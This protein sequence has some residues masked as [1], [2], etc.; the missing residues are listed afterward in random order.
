[1]ASSTVALQVVNVET[2]DEVFSLDGDRALVPASV[3]KAVTAAAALRTLGPTYRFKTEFL[4]DGEVNGDGVL[5]GNLYIR[6]GG[7]PSLVIE[8]LWKMF[9]DL[10]VEGIVEIDGDLIFDDTWFDREHLIAGWNKKVDIAAG[11]A[12]FAPISALSL[13]YNTVSIIVA[14][15][16]KPGDPARVQLETPA[17]IVALESEVETLR[18]GKRTWI[19]VEREVDPETHVVTF[20]IEGAIAAEGKIE[21]HYRAVGNPIA[22]TMSATDH[23]FKQTGVTLNGRFKL[24]KTPED[25]EPVVQHY[26]QPLHELLNH[27]NKYSSNIM[28]E[29]ILKAMGAEVKGDPGTT[30]NGLEVV[31]EYLD[32]LGIPREEYTVVNGSGL[33]RDAL[34]APSQVNA[35]M[36]DMFHHP[37]LAPE[38][39]SS[40]SVGGVDGT[41]RRRFD[42]QPGA[43]RGKTG[44]LNGVYCLTSYVR[45]QTGDTYALTFFAN[46]LRRS[47]P[48]R[49]LQDAIGEAIMGWNGQIEAEEV[50]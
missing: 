35:V 9:Q 28:A 15:A 36:M 18:K 21:R 2:G 32:E 29:H 41:L 8:K 43:V 17:R 7:D 16:F 10:Q 45:A 46:D 33:T 26:S 12:Y 50:E 37:Q 13:N 44:S 24:D 27:T 3:T 14:P 4:R 39:L 31:R 48:A 23:L 42:E 22:W 11:P 19:Q 5:E 20:K 40:L 47:R 49:A 38:F 6:G 1:V 25:A 30:E 34:L